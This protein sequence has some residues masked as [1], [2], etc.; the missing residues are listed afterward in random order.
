[1]DIRFMKYNNK[2]L[3]SSGFGALDFISDNFEISVPYLVLIS[4][5]TLNGCIG[6]VMVIGAVWVYKVIIMNVYW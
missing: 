5:F 6:N 4:A 1:M 3:N 2:T